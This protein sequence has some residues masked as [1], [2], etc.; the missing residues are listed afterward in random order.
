MHICV[1]VFRFPTRSETFVRG[2]V[3]GLLRR[4]HRVTVLC[5]GIGEG[6]SKSE[7]DE[8]LALG[9]ELVFQPNFV[10]SRVKNFARMIGH[11]VRKP[12]DAKWLARRPPWTRA[13]T[14]DAVNRCAYLHKIKPDVVHVHFGTI[15]GPLHRILA[16]HNLSYRMV[17]T[18]HGYDVNHQTKSRGSDIY[19]ELFEGQHRHTVGSNFIRQRLVALGCPSKF[20]SVVPMGTD[21]NRFSCRQRTFHIGETL[22]VV[23][24]GRL[25]EEK[26]YRFL[27]QAVAGLIQKGERV[28]LRIIGDGPLRADLEAQILHH[29]LP[30][31]SISLLGAKPTDEVIKELHNAHV[32]AMTGVVATNGQEEGQGVVYAEAQA[33]GLPVIACRLGGAPES[34]LEGVSGIV[35]APAD[36]NAISDAIHFFLKNPERITEYGRAGRKFAETRFSLSQMLDAFEQIYA[37]QINA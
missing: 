21:I 9:L 35:C 24:I 15:A 29:K 31:E 3:E 18:W 32:F 7:V 34:L 16:Q 4:G 6:I 10:R 20:A 36:V 14:F 2:H 33:C 37:D 13:E 26:G 1:L 27:I 25:N 19:R 11:I 23:S 22:R 28:E 30:I 17:V 12:A 8:L 5:G